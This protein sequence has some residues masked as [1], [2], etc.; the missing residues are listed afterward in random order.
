MSGHTAQAP[1][2]PSDAEDPRIRALAAQIKKQW[3]TLDEIWDTVRDGT[4]I[5]VRRDTYTDPND[6]LADAL[7]TAGRHGLLRTLALEIIAHD[8][9][10]DEFDDR[11]SE[12][13][14]DSALR[15]EAF[16]PDGHAPVNAVMYGRGLAHACQ[17]VCRI[18]IDGQHVGTGVLVRP[19]L[20][21]TAAHVILPLLQRVPQPSLETPEVQPMDGS[22]ARLVLTFGDHVDLYG[23]LGGAA[24][25]RRDGAVAELHTSWLAW[26]SEPTARE[27]AQAHA[28]HDITDIAVP[29]GPWDLALIRLARPRSSPPPVRGAQVPR[30]EFAIHLLHHPGNPTGHSEPLLLSNGTIDRHLGQP[31]VR[32]LHNASTLRGSSGAPLFNDAWEVVALHQGGPLIRQPNGQP[33]ATP[34]DRNRAVPVLPWCERLDNIDAEVPPDVRYIRT[35]RNSPD[36]LV[37]RYPVI[38]RRVTQQRLWRALHATASSERLI[39]V[40]GLPGTGLRFTTHLA[41]DF[42]KTHGG[43][44]VAMDIANAQDEHAFGVAHRLA[45]TLHASIAIGATAGLTTASRSLHTDVVPALGAAL[46]AHA[47]GKPVFLILEGFSNNIEEDSP[48]V[49]DL[50]DAFIGRLAD[51]TL[52][53]VLVGWHGDLPSQYTSCVDELAMPTADDVAQYVLPPGQEASQQLRGSIQSLLDGEHRA[54]REGYRAARRVVGTLLMVLREA[55]R[56]LVEEGRS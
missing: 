39:V 2:L 22:L 11:L 17:H 23:G 48:G 21:A 38:G 41:S 14:G 9:H 44:V 5:R 49:R 37:E 53:L 51:T 19:R 54:G 29:D 26:I 46:T 15:F 20:V 45:G 10:R 27:R 32:C 28:I 4:A 50:V 47:D 3:T 43:T 52:R 36:P 33:E 1:S 30:S 12:V 42:V 34:Q 35:L 31:P 8:L 40:R 24:A 25:R 7:A 16:V 13:M 55:D 6:F 18:D 56:D